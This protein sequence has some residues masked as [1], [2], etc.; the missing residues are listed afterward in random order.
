MLVNV[1]SFENKVK[2]SGNKVISFESKVIVCSENDINYENKVIIFSEK[3]ISYESK[4]KMCNDM[5]I[6]L[7]VIELKLEIKNEEK[8]DFD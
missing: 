3:V 4:V 8:M 5:E 1:V 6:K 2:I 7:F